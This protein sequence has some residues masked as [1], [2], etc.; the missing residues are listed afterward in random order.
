MMAGSQRRSKRITTRIYQKN[1]QYRTELVNNNARGYHELAQSKSSILPSA[2]KFIKRRHSLNAGIDIKEISGECPGVNTS[3]TDSLILK[4]SEPKRAN[5]LN[6]GVVR[7]KLSGDGTRITCKQQFVNLSYTLVDEAVSMSEHGNYLLAIAKCK[8]YNASIKS[9]VRD[10]IQEFD[11]LSCVIIY[12]KE[13]KIDKYLGGDLKYLN[14]I[15]GIA[16]FAS[17]FLCL[18]CHCGSDERFDMSKLWSM[19]DTNMGARTIEEIIQCSHKR[20]NDPLK[21]N[22]VEEP[23]FRLVPIYNVIPDTLYLCL[24]ISDQLVRHTISYLRKM[25]NIE[26]C[27]VT[28]KKLLNSKHIHSF[29]NFIHDV[30]GIYDWKFCISKDGKL[31]YRSFHGPE[32]RKLLENIDLDILIPSHPKLL[33]LKK[34][35][36]D[37]R[38]LMSEMDIHLL[39][40]QVVNFQTSAKKWV[41]LYYQANC[42]TDITPYMHVLAFHLPEAMKLHGNVSHFCQQGL[43]TVND[44][45]TK[46]YHRSTNFGRNAM[47]QIM[48]KQYRLHLLADRCTRKK[49]WSTQCSICKRKGHNKRSCGQKEE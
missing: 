20:A 17:K 26:K 36:R 22:C 32:H 12:G 41:D 10:L 29:E 34:L 39:E 1:Q 30:V 18:W 2:G 5:L 49:K 35:W 4:L 27:S 7:I 43:E 14:Q 42:S 15:V 19:T 40:V 23:V 46:W 25:D 44:L 8:E 33:E 48:A 9:A 37:F 38:L 6:D 13:V 31:K 28:K 47:G 21:Y 16:G 3:L 45:V 24:R 11:T